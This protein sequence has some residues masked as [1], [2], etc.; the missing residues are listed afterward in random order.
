M[1]TVG[2]FLRP[3]RAALVAILAAVSVALVAVP[4]HAAP[5]I[6]EY[7][8]GLSPNGAPHGIAEG[9]DGS[10]WFTLY[11]KDGVGRISPSGAITEYFPTLSKGQPEG[12][13]LGPDGNMWFVESGAT[14]AIARIDPSGSVTEFTT[15][16]NPLG[17]PRDI[18]A[19]S[20][21]ALWFTE[22]G[23]AIGRIDPATG[24]ITEYS[25]GLSL[26]SQ[27]K[28]ITAGPDG[29]LW[30]TQKG[31]P[32][33]IG[34][35]TPAGAITEFS[36][37]LTSGSQPEDIAA[38][39]D[40]NLWFTESGDPGGIGRIT[41]AGVITEFS[42]GLTPDARPRGIAPGA[43]GNMWFTE[44]GDGGEGGSGGRIGRITPSGAITE[45]S[46]GLTPGSKPLRI[47]PG[48][49]GNMWFTEN[50]D[51]GTIGRITVPP[52]ASTQDPSATDHRSATL[53]AR[54]RPNSQA[55]TYSFEWGTTTAY[56]NETSSAPAGGGATAQTVAADISG[57]SPETTYHYR[58][59]ATNDSGTTY[60][61]D[62]VLT[63]E[64][65]P[66]PDVVTG[67]ASSVTLT[68][69]TLGGTVNPNGLPTS[70]HFEWGIDTSYGNRAP[71]SDGDAGSGGSEQAVSAD[72][73]GLSPA[74]TYH[75]RLV[76][77]NASGTTYGADQTFVSDPSAPAVATGSPGAVDQTT[78]TLGGTVNPGGRA[79]TYS[80]QWGA[81]QGYGTESPVP[82][83]DAGSSTAAR[84]VTTDLTGLAPGTTYHYRLVA[85]NSAGT[86]YGAD[87]SFETD[88]PPPA[89]TTNPATLVDQTSARLGSTVNPR[90]LPTTYRFE[91]GTS[92]EYGS[93]APLSEADAGSDDIDHDLTAD[94]SGL[95]PSTTYHYRVVAT[96]AS[97][98]SY[99]ADRSFRTAPPPPAA[100]TGAASL[101]EA[102][103]ATLNAT[104]NPNGA[105][106]TYRF[107]WGRS[108]EY[109]SS[110]PATDS[111]VGS[112]TS[113]QQLAQAV[114]GLT[115]G[116][117]YHFRVVATNAA[118][119]TYGADRSF[120]TRSAE[121]PAEEQE[122][123]AP[124]AGAPR[125]PP[126]VAPNLG[127]TVTLEPA[128]GSVRIRLPGSKRYLPLAEAS[129]VPTGSRI[130]TRR[131]TV[132]LTSVR[133][134]GGRLQTGTFWGDVFRIQQR[135]AQRH[136]TVLDLR[137][138]MRCPAARR[139]DALARAAGSRS[140]RGLWGRDRG[141]R[142]RTRGRH[143]AAT[144]RGTKWLTRDGCAATT[145]RVKRGAVVVRDFAR[146]R[147]VLLRAGHSYRA[148]RH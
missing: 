99:G 106:T 58:V 98:T 6:T 7:T 111:A 49:D 144:V 37:G 42:A 9:A 89:A 110:I 65:A 22:K 41:P 55:T 10:T 16:L 29:N 33:S 132:R 80:F 59:V 95:S 25:L 24:S 20:D 124:E 125:L 92:S 17:Q 119:T 115:A 102:T 83:G 79:T 64:A 36:A 66:Q 88:P 134:A 139:A 8:A 31:N 60:G 43:D 67:P 46:A 141:G 57:L 117:T 86:S 123:P 32:G 40:G 54:I 63:T 140:R 53:R 28:A 15:G 78:A 138:P 44:E 27:P 35:I 45:F 19:G 120:T 103:S 91:W 4:A 104:V 72:I 96:N 3:R 90:G 133:G 56:G 107:E 105:A 34:R 77:T 39:P 126:A 73:A 121:P 142:F 130:E 52:G 48:A 75:F 147:N 135:R 129:T 146:R 50:A 131:G 23:D 145:F 61:E 38:G 85:T 143:G 69:A 108:S 127:R 136:V 84:A 113:G 47:A 137:R 114:S 21:G 14:G 26:G 74:T 122:G 87:Q 70:Y 18:A 11:A 2:S 116:T 100:T 82:A 109:G 68:S 148:K 112:D 97:G 128:S 101:I 5:T 93:Q 13:T 71:A 118:G 81:D 12:I 51:P 1:R 30:F 62:R 76:A 94:L